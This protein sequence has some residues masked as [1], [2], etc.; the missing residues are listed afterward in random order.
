MLE[1]ELTVARSWKQLE[2]CYKLAKTK[3]HTE[4]SFLKNGVLTLL[5][6]S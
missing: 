6:T 3:C 2:I 4:K 5:T 1:R